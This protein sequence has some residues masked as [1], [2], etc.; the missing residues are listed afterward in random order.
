MLEA[1]DM[2]DTHESCGR[3]NN[4]VT[5]AQALSL[6]NDKVALDWARGFAGRLL[7]EAGSDTKAQIDR[8]W[9]LAYSRKPEASEKDTVLTFLDKQQKIIAARA[10]ANSKISLPLNMPEG[11]D[12][13][14]AAALVDLCHML[15]SSNEFVYRN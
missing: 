9:L 13:V 4:T 12:P 2:P 6:L 7:R 15:L 11:A 3:R 10:T 14:H 8:A 5:P 1:F